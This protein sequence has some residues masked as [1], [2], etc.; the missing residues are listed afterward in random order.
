MDVGK[1]Y[2]G[3]GDRLERYFSW[4]SHGAYNERVMGVGG[5]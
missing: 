1:I 5:I 2:Y 3:R 4:T